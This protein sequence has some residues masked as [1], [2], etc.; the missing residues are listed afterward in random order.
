MESLERSEEMVQPTDQTLMN[1]QANEAPE[2]VAA[3]NAEVCST[4]QLDK[5]GIIA[6]LEA[7]SQNDDAAIDSDETARLKRLFYSIEHD[8]QQQAFQ[9]YIDGGG[10]AEEYIAEVDP[11]EEQ[12]KELLNTIKEKKARERERLEA[13]L[14][15]NAE[16]KNAII[17]EFEAMSADTDN[18]N[19]HFQR[20]KELQAEFKA[21]GEVPQEQ[22]TALWKN[23]TAAVERFYDQLKVNKELRDYDFKKNLAEKQ[24]ILSQT[25]A[26]AEEADVITAF[27]RLQELH[28]KW[29]E[30]GPVA[31]ELRDQ[32]WNDF[33]DASAVVSKRYQAYFEE[34]KANER[35]N[36]EA[37]TAI[38]EAMEALDLSAAKTF[39]DW[40]QLTDKVM[41]AQAQ[42]KTIGQASRKT[43]NALY[44]RFRAACDKFFAAKAEH[45]KSVKDSL[46]ENLQRKT[47]L[48]EK[49][50]ALKDSTDWRKTTD[51]IVALQKEWRTIGAVPKKS[52]DA[53]WRRFMDACDYFFE[54]KKKQ[55]QSTRTTERAN[56]QTK[57]DIIAKLTALNAP[58]CT[59]ERAEAVKQI[60]ELRALWKETGHVPFKEKDALA[61]QYREVVG[62]LFEKYDLRENRARMASFESNIDKMSSDDNKL[63]R[64]RE[65]LLRAH[66]QRCAEL[67]TY[68]NNLGFLNFK[69][70]S[71]EE[72]L[73]QMNSKMQHIKDEIAEIEKKIAIIDSKL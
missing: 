24:L 28:Q 42:W 44:S 29:R 55:T 37:K 50:E 71:G 11:R 3:E 51:A 5:D 15:A 52:S 66:D 2:A 63:L 27:K 39:N 73:R 38:C 31:K 68:E 19:R 8:Q 18:V 17:A 69:S 7:M 23:Y 13:L 48:C 34:R 72:M 60:Q 62:Q 58:E 14:L 43:N 65:R 1:E 40:N 9:N 53:I 56:L 20:A 49:V 57:R 61:E 6:A 47:E 59:T 41:E 36:E 30:T 54:Q 32:L 25:V 12:L 22:A 67:K 16:R 33:R 35:A 45:F 4:P 70:R 64:E 46:S 10:N 26:L 21:V